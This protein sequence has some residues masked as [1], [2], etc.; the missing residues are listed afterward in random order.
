MKDL[1]GM[2][3]QVCP[4][5]KTVKKCQTNSVPK[6]PYSGNKTCASFLS[7]SRRQSTPNVTFKEGEVENKQRSKSQIK[8]VDIQCAFIGSPMLSTP[9]YASS[10]KVIGT[11]YIYFFYYYRK[12]IISIRNALLVKI[13]L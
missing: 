13:K 5:L 12:E 7:I 11:V 10:S 4:I 3:F 1:V 6:K 8:E 2:F 9:D